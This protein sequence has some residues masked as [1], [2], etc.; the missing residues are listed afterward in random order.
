MK[1]LKDKSVIIIFICAFANV[2]FILIATKFC[3]INIISFVICFGLG[4]HL[5]YH[6]IQ[7]EKRMEELSYHKDR[8]EALYKKAQR[9]YNK[10][11]NY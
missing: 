5:I 4:L 11:H 1:H 3:I 8:I 2:P 9:H 10:T 7:H 6:N